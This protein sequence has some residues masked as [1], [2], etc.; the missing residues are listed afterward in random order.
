MLQSN[1]KVRTG[2]KMISGL[3]GWT[4]E[5]AA[6]FKAGNPPTFLGWQAA[7]TEVEYI[8]PENATALI[9]A[10]L[11]KGR[12]VLD[13]ADGDTLEVVYSECGAPEDPTYL[14]DEIIMKLINC[15]AIDKRIKDIM[16]LAPDEYGRN[17]MIHL[18]FACK[19]EANF[20]ND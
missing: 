18:T 11:P 16:L 7:I 3:A 15:V 20:G 19:F 10:I 1:G 2:E 12:T 17:I 8:D 5:N 6:L 4:N 13:I 9:S 14:P